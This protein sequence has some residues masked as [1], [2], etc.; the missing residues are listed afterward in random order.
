MDNSGAFIEGSCHAITIRAGGWAGLGAGRV[1]AATAQ[2][3][4][5]IGQPN[6]AGGDGISV[7]GTGELSARP[8]LVEVD[9]HIS[10]RAE[11]TGDALVK[12][13]DAK[14]RGAQAL[15]KL[16]LPNL[17]TEE[18]A[19]GISAGTSAEQQ[20][21]MMNGMPQTPSKPQIDVSSTLR[22]RLKDVRQMQSEELIKLVGKLLDVSQDAGLS[23]G[24]NAAEV[25]R[26]MRMGNYNNNNAAPVR[27]VVTDLAEIREKA[28]EEAV[29]DVRSRATRLAKLNQ[30]KLGGALSV[31]EVLV[32]GDRLMTSVNNVAVETVN[33]DDD[34]GPRIASTSLSAIPVQVRLL[35]RF[36]ILPLDPATAVNP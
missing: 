30:V 11:L 34:A 22:V 23:I 5:A 36:A 3:Q 26:N 2:G 1:G 33:D 29:A 20:Q 15:D 32:A 28:Y 14:K 8:N 12:Y 9:L 31:Q 19:L 17:L 16:K 18:L 27:F 13:R 7:S 4:I 6:A 21:R 24:P 10:G 35:V 25:M